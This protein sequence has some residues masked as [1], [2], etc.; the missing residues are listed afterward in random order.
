[1]TLKVDPRVQIV[2]VESTGGTLTAAQ[3]TF[4]QAWLGSKVQ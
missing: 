1:V 2:P 4:R 3:R